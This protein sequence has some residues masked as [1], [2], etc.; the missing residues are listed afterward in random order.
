M[1]MIFTHHDGRTQEC[2]HEDSL[3]RELSD[4]SRICLRCGQTVTAEQ[5]TRPAPRGEGPAPQTRRG[6]VAHLRAR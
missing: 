4:G 2:D 5:F 3:G 1:S 6:R